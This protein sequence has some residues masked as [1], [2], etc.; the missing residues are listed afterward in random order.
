MRPHFHQCG[1]LLLEF[2]AGIGSLDF[3][4]LD[5]GQARFRNRI[6]EGGRFVGSPGLKACP[7]GAV[8]RGATI[9]R[10]RQ[11]LR[12]CG[13][14]HAEHQS[15]GFQPIRGNARGRSPR[16]AARASRHVAGLPSCGRPECSTGR[17]PRSKSQPRASTTS[18]T[19]LAHRTVNSSTLALTLVR[20]R[21]LPISG[22]VSPPW[23]RLVVLDL[24]GTSSS[25]AAGAS[26]VF[27][28]KGVLAAAELLRL[29]RVPYLLA[30]A[31]HPRRSF[32]QDS[33]KR[34]TVQGLLKRAHRRGGVERPAPATRRCADRGHRCQACCAI[35]GGAW[36]CAIRLRAEA[37][38]R[39]AICSKPVT[40]LRR[41]QP[42]WRLAAGAGWAQ[43][44]STPSATRRAVLRVQLAGALERGYP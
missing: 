34:R 37:M 10:Q 2:A 26:S 28:V 14:G 31:A 11:H 32:G 17:W 8:D 9:T 3:V 36:G 35:A 1:A 33:R 41:P 6:A 23:H 40:T 22:G 27:P 30:P 16:P 21:S 20:A 13:A 42:R 15:V 39:S 12:Q 24:C 25:P 29:G 4:A 44:G 7:R 38:N 18:L 19:L 5:V 43:R